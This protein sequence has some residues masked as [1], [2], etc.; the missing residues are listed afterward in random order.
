MLASGTQVRGE[1]NGKGVQGNVLCTFLGFVGRFVLR[2]LLCGVWLRCQEFV[3][4]FLV[5]LLC[6]KECFGGGS[7]YVLLGMGLV[8]SGRHLVEIW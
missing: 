5:Y 4:C 8:S 6:F 3:C 7:M 1:G 2:R